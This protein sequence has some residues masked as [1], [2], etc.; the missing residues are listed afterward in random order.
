MIGGQKMSGGRGRYDKPMGNQTTGYPGDLAQIGHLFPDLNL[1]LSV[2]LGQR[3]DE[4]PIGKGWFFF[5][6]CFEIIADFFKNNFKILILALRHLQEI[7]DHL[8]DIDQNGGDPGTDKGHTVALAAVIDLFQ[9]RHGLQGIVISRQESPETPVPLS[10]GSPKLFR[11][12]L[13][14]GGGIESQEA[15]KK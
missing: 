14:L 11:A 10:E 15:P 9:F 1:C 2:D 7:A 5:D 13:R 4:G 8:I 3:Q 6:D 12:L